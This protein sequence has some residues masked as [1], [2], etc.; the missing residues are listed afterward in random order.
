MRYR[1][2]TR[3]SGGDI[4][5]SGR[6][7]GLLWPSGLRPSRERHAYIVRTCHKGYYGNRK[8]RLIVKSNMA[9]HVTLILVVV[10]SQRG[11][12]LVRLRL[13]LSAPAPAPG[14]PDGIWRG[15]SGPLGAAMGAASSPRDR[16]H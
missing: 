7:G 16:A 11:R 6:A 8:N 15:R 4:A 13:R 14:P 9:E 12:L 2:D 3:Q 5:A 10:A 1:A